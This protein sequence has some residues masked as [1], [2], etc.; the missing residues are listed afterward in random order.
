VLDVQLLDDIIGNRLLE[1]ARHQRF[2]IFVL[3]LIVSWFAE[4]AGV[5]EG[6]IFGFV[7]A[8]VRIVKVWSV[9][10]HWKNIMRP[11][12]WRS[13][14]TMM[15]ADDCY[16]APCGNPRLAESVSRMVNLGIEFYE[17][18]EVDSAREGKEGA[19]K[20]NEK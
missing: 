9:R 19:E 15:L 20:R 17:N 2:R 5:E 16:H 18:S 1:D 14:R 3:S 13:S 7:R 12:G 11:G 10:V 4:R 6:R 8:T